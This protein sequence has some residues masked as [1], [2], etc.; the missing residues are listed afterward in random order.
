MKNKQRSFNCLFLA[1]LCA[2]HFNNASA[3]DTINANNKWRFLI[4]PYMMFPN[5]N[6]TVGMGNL[7]DADVDQDPGDI[8]SKFKIGAMLYAEA[9][10]RNWTISSDVTYM[11]LGSDVAGKHGIITGD[12]NVEQLAWELAGLYK[13][14]PWLDAGIGFQLNNIKSDLNLIVN[15]GSGP[16]S[17]SRSINE[18]WVDPSVIARIKLPLSEKWFFQFRGNVG[19]F[20]I[21]SD[22]YWQTQAYFGYRFSKLFQLSAGYRIISIDYEKGSGA[23]HFLYDMNTFGSVLRIG[24]NL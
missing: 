13:L 5:M 2:V 17:R 1:I 16:Q 8:F 22:F 9:S 14:K 15:T 11:K 7:P 6:G 24:F 23:D 21:G 19:G 10:K 12:A 18:S 4:E 20:G 3:Q